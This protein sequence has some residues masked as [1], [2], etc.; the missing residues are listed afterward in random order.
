MSNTVSAR[1]GDRSWI[2]SGMRIGS[3]FSGIGGLELGLERAGLGHVVWQIEID[4]F[5]RAV[6]AKHWPSVTR[7]ED[8]RCVT[9]ASS[10]LQQT[11]GSDVALPAVPSQVAQNKQSETTREEVMPSEAIDAVRTLLGID[12][13]VGG[14]P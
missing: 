14:F 3:V 2:E 1:L 7:Y 8:V 4:P 5:C 12:I 13:L 9:G 10:G 6:L 11:H